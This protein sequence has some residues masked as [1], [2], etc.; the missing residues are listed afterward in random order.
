M[1]ETLKVGDPAPPFE[2]VALGGEYGT[3]QT[4]RLADFAG[5]H[6]VLYFYPK[7]NTPGCT[8]QA[9]GL[10]DRWPDYQG[11]NAA[12]FG[13]S[14]DSLASHRTF[15]DKYG[16]PFPL[17]SDEDGKIVRAYGVWVEKNLYGQKTMGT[18]RSTFVIGPDGHI[19][20]IF[21]RVKPDEH[22]D[23]VLEVL[24]K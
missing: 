2:A 13:V 6:L 7:D 10:R 16:L 24:R 12:V 17:L 23:A 15:I 14:T 4:V 20:E 1:N 3:G 8:T 18:E 11:V 9:C 21:R 22:A 19:K 5:K